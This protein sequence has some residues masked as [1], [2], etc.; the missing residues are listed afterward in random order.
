MCA[1]FGCS[2]DHCKVLVCRATKQNHENKIEAQKSQDN[3]DGI[4]VA[5]G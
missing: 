3:M 5:S 1:K 2:R 4:D